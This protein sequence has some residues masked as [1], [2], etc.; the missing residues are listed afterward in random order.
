MNHDRHDMPS[1]FYKSRESIR[2]V[3]NMACN[4]KNLT[5]LSEVPIMQK[6]FCLHNGVEAILKS[7]EKLYHTACISFRIPKKQ[8]IST[9]NGF[10]FKKIN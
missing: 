5:R 7:H 3:E 6:N 10:I 4:F 8:A 1:L 2:H 9:D